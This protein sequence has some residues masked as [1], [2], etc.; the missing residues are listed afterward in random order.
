M[1]TA[2]GGGEESRIEGRQSSEMVDAR[3]ARIRKRQGNQARWGAQG[4]RGEDQRELT[5]TMRNG[6]SESDL[7]G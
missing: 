6:V 1:G 7:T 3:D 4:S 2:A 5:S